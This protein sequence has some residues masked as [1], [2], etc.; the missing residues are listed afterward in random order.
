M[1]IPFRFHAVLPR[2]AGRTDLAVLA[3]NA[4][5]LPDMAGLV[6]QEPLFFFSGIT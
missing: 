3:V 1:G 5:S 4:G 2:C 6:A